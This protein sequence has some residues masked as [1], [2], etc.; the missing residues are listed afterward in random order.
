MKVKELFGTGISFEEFLK[1]DSN[2]Y[3]EKTIEVF[4][5]INFEGDNINR[6]KNIDKSINVLICAEIW[7]PDCMI[8]V[9]VVGK[10]RQ[11]NENIRI[12][13]VDKEGNEEFFKSFN[14]EGVLKIPTFVFF[15]ENFNV[16]GS[17]IERPNVVK[18]VYN[19]GNQPEIIVTM[20]KYRKGEYTKETLKDILQI[21]GY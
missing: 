18:E 2:A 1:L 20:R 10:M 13:I 5:N 3:K 15:D 19:R 16:L 6:I 7:C 21:L 4:N 17:F 8:N 9:P 12:S 11:I 14:T